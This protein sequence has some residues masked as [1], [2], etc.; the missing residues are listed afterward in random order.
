MARPR[1]H[2][3][4]T[5]DEL[6]AAAAGLLAAAGPAALSVRQVADAAGTSHRAVYALFGSKQGLVDALATHGYADLAGRVRGLPTTDDAAGDLVR[7]G[8]HGFR[9][10]AL[11]GPALFRLTFEQ[12]SAEVLRQHRV[13]EAA[14]S[15][16]AALEE[17]VARARAAGRVHPDRSDG[18]CIFVFHATCQGLASCELAAQPPPRGPGFWR[19][20]TASDLDAA[21]HDTLT[22]VVTGF[23]TPPTGN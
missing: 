21:W 10:F 14:R 6:L 11:E 8:T 23:G 22:A 5:G 15:S 9:A 1:I 12:V 16:Y 17:R 2:D 18:D 13:T 20:R 7:A 3:D 4:A 19:G